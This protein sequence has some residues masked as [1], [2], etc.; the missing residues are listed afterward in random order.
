MGESSIIKVKLWAEV[1]PTEDIN[2]VKTA[3]MNLCPTATFKDIH[4][5]PEGTILEAHATGPEAI[6]TLA[7]KFREQRILQAVRNQLLQLVQD[8]MLA[9]GIQ[10]QAAFVNRFHLCDLNDET[11]MGPIQ[12][13]IT[14]TR[15]QDIIDYISPATV[16]GK[17]QFRKNLQLE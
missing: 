12:V 17:P 8:N 4:H 3:I 2:K 5:D 14:A 6:S 7:K 10:R 1:Q 9:F 13:E 16:K 15:M 11:A